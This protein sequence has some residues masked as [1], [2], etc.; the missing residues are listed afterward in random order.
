VG[1]EVLQ[2]NDVDVLHA[3]VWC[4]A[5]GLGSQCLIKVSEGYP[6][7]GFVQNLLA[8]SYEQQ[9]CSPRGNLD[10]TAPD[11]LCNGPA[12]VILVSDF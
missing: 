12:F 9:R 2:Q 10:L 11:L 8:G 6:A 4:M 7:Q 5:A 3:Q 1:S